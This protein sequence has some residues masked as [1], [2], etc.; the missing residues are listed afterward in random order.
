M[1]SKPTLFLAT[2]LFI[3]TGCGHHQVASV[4]PKGGDKYE[5]VGEGENEQ[6]AYKNAESEARYTCENNSEKKLTVLNE[7]SQYQGANKEDK[8]KVSGGNIAL[9]IFTGHSGK[10]RSAD[11]Y[12]VKLLISCM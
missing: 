11:D 5:V 1:N 2:L 8:D 7:E 9:A 6:E 3:G 12:K 10:E 4:L